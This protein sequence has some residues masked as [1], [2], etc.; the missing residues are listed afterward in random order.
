M[1]LLRSLYSNHPVIFALLVYTVFVT[2]VFHSLILNLFTHSPG[3]DELVAT[4]KSMWHYNFLKKLFLFKENFLATDY[5]FY[6]FETNLIIDSNEFVNAL[7]TL[8]FQIFG[9]IAATNILVIL[10]YITTGL[11]VYLFCYVNSKSR[12]GSLVAGLVFTF[13]PI[14]LLHLSYGSLNIALCWAVPFH[15]Y[16][17]AKSVKDQS[18]LFA[19]LS[20]LFLGVVTYN[21][22]TMLA[23][24]LPASASYALYL[25]FSQRGLVTKLTA[26]KHLAISYMSWLTLSFP[27]FY[28]IN[29][30]KSYIPLEVPLSV[31]NVWSASLERFFTPTSLNILLGRFAN[32]KNQDEY[33][34][35]IGIGVFVV[36]LLSTLKLFLSKMRDK[37]LLLWTSISWLFLILSLGPQLHINNETLLKVGDMKIYVPMPFLLYQKIPLIGGIQEPLRFIYPAAFSLSIVAGIFIKDLLKSNTGFARV[38]LWLFLVSFLV[39]YLL[40]SVPVFKYSVP[41]VYYDIAKDNRDYSIV[42]VPIGRVTGTG[43]VG[44]EIS[45]FSYYQTIHDKKVTNGFVARSPGWVVSEY[46]KTKLFFYLLELQKNGCPKDY[47]VNPENS[48]ELQRN[49]NDLNVGYIIIHR[50]FFESTKDISCFIAESGLDV[51][52]NTKDIVVLKRI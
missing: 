34:L 3:F 46:E 6:P 17:L 19:I 22:L 15:F 51:V 48:V 31:Q 27:L 26:T 39:E 52:E 43:G 25:M 47:I 12:L 35:Y 4:G 33:G 38:L 2:V 11:G 1:R 49:M 45:A 50:R 20:G 21:Y 5:I 18:Y 41:S 40:T 8:P 24:F 44:K 16:F 36:L 42:D 37:Q 23:V 9:L 10:S 30:A 7:V 32:T 13:A 29:Q 28:F 14:S